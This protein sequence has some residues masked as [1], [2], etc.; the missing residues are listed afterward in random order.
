[1]PGLIQLSE[2]SDD[3]RSYRSYRNFSDSGRTCRRGF[4]LSELS[5]RALSDYGRGHYRTIG[6]IGVLSECYRSL[7][8]ELSDQ[9][10]AE[11]PDEDAEYSY[12]RNILFLNE[13]GMQM[14]AYSDPD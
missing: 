8:S 14:T 13:L 3:Y 12:E 5:E 11:E 2:L 10:S 4:P 6:A 1:M 7:L 9:G